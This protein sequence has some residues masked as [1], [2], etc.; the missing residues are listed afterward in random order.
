MAFVRTQNTVIKTPEQIPTIKE[1]NVSAVTFVIG[2][3]LVHGLDPAAKCGRNR[4]LAFELCTHHL[5]D[6]HEVCGC[7]GNH[8]STLRVRIVRS[9]PPGPPFAATSCGRRV[10]SADVVQRDIRI[11]LTLREGRRQRGVMSPQGVK[12]QAEGEQQG[13]CEDN[14]SPGSPEDNHRR[15]HDRLVSRRMR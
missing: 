7:H 3:N 15:H 13:Q 11:L 10:S 2:Q 5:P 12:Q 9:E 8:T 4:H 1:S 14:D 6:N